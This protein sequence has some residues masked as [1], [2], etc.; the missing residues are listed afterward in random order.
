MHPPTK[1]GGNEGTY[2]G[3]V[4]RGLKSPEINRVM[5]ACISLDF[6]PG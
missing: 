5:I 2:L 1:V 3:L 4:Y 6:S